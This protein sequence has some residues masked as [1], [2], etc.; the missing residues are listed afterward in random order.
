MEGAGLRC[1]FFGFTWLKSLEFRLCS[2]SLAIESHL[3]LL[4]LKPFEVVLIKYL[5]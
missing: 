3:W 1:A 5:Q 4:V 2:S